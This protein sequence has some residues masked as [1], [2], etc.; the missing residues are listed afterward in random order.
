M[1]TRRIIAAL[2]IVL[3]ST[4]ALTVPAGAA[5]ASTPERPSHS[6]RDR[7]DG[8]LGDR[9]V[10]FVGRWDTSDPTTYIGNWESPYVRTTFVGTTIQAKVRDKASLYVSIDNAPDVYYPDAQGT[11]DLTPTPLARGVHTIWLTYRT[12][13]IPTCAT[14]PSPC[15]TFQGFV[16]G[17]GGRTVPTRPSHTLL[18]FVGDSITLGALSSQNTVTSYSWLVGEKLGVKH[19]NIS[20][21]GACLVALSNCMGIA[22]NFFKQTIGGTTDWDF[23]RYQADAVVI[24]LGTNDAGRGVSAADFQATYT[25]FLAKIR[26]VYP[27]AALFAFETFRQRYLPET[28]AAV[29]ARLDAGDDRVYYINTEGWLTASD[30]V[31]GG[32]PNDGGHAKIAERLAPIISA[33]LRD[34]DHDERG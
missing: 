32:H 11:I 8:S 6:A 21:P 2:T 17:R 20:R 18:E 25:Q 5:V 29:Q 31:D 33:A 13:E 34:R 14:W 30:F 23:T 7:A 24:N 12:G 22:D 19:T 26:A 9:N 15:A 3:A 4:V 16:L 28:Q 10:Q 27:H 1:S